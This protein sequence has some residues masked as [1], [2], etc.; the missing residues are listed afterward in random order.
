MKVVLVLPKGDNDVSRVHCGTRSIAVIM[1]NE[2][3][4]P[5]QWT[6]FETTI[7]AVEA[8]TGYDLF[9]NLPADVEYCVEAF[10]DG[11]TQVPD[12]TPPSIHC[13]AADAAW[14]TDNVT[15]SCTATDNESGLANAGDASF[16]LST[17]VPDGAETANAATDTRVVCDA[18]GN[19]ATAGPITGNRVDRKMPAVTCATADGAWH[20]DNVS[21][22]CTANDAGAGVSAPDAAFSLATSVAAGSEDTS[23][24][25]GSVSV[26]DLVGHCTTAG[27]ITGNKID[28]KNPT[29]SVTSP[30]NGAS[31]PL[32]ALVAASF[33]C[34]DTGSGVAACAGSVA[35]GALID[36]AS[37]GP[38][39][40]VVSV[41]DVAGNTATAS[42]AYTVTNGPDNKRTPGISITNIPLHAGPGGSFTPAFSYDGDGNIHLRSLTPWVCTIKADSVVTFVSTGTCTLVPWATAS[43]SVNPARGAPQSFAV[44]P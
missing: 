35:N 4:R 39:T 25:T 44:A 41:T 3:L 2:E 17:L 12:V 34:A 28:R 18:V 31:Y 27:P 37:T 13:D 30:A 36:T 22:A 32:G 42:V 23:A 11:E 15:L 5:H 26:C 24:S 8:L 16:T 6:E 21:I 9:S 14:H 33:T 7:D 40:F 20:A 38:T 1:P 43:G 10:K 19:C 29:I